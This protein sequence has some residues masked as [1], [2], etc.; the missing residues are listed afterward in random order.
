MI[1]NKIFSNLGNA[2]VKK[3]SNNDADKYKDL[4][5]QNNDLLN[6]SMSGLGSEAL[7]N[8]A[9]GSFQAMQ[10]LQELNRQLQEQMRKNQ[11]NNN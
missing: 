7:A 3:T 4:Q 1:L 10:N 8:T 5:K 2:A 6:Q 11:Q 9:K